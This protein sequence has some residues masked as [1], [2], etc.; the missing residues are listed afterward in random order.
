MARQTAAKT[1]T[2]TKQTQKYHFGKYQKEAHKYKQRNVVLIK[3]LPLSSTLKDSKKL[4]VLFRG[5]MTVKKVL[6]NDRYHVAA[7]HGS[8]RAIHQTNYD[9][10]ITVDR[11]K[12]G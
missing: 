7:I 4:A 2:L 3:K 10:I 9:K 1:N 12:P 6:P 11:M 8:R 5:L